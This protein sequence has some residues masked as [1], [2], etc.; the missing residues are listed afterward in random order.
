MDKYHWRVRL[1]YG[2]DN[3][4][5]KGL[6]AL[7]GLLGL[8]S[9][10]FIA[11]ISGIVAIFGLYPPD[12]P[13]GFFEVFWGSLLRTLDPGT[14]GQDDG[15]GFRAAML[16][17]TLSGVILVASLIGVIS[18]AFNARI[19]LLRKG[20]SR[21]LEKDHTLI[22]GWNSKVFS[23]IREISVANLSRTNPCIVILADRDK[24]EMEDEIH[25]KLKKISNSR[26][27][28]RSGDPM[29]LIDLEIANPNQARSIVILASDDDQDSDSV[30]I[31]ICMALVNSASR[32][33]SDYHIV[34]EIKEEENLEAA[35]LVGGHEAHWILGDD[36]IARL[37]VQTS[38]QSGLSAVF[39]ELLDFDG[40]ELYPTSQ[41]TLVGKTYGEAL[42]AF[43]RSCVLGLISGA[44]VEL[45]P[46]LGRKISATDQILVISEDDASIELGEPVAVDTSNFAQASRPPTLPE[47]TLILGINRKIVEILEEMSK[48]MANGSQ[49]VV[50][51]NQPP[52]PLKNIGSL[53]VEFLESDPTDRRVLESMDVKAFDHIVVLADLERFSVQRG[54]ARTLLTLL[55]LRDMAK[56]QGASL[57]IVSEMLDDRNRE[58]A[59]STDADDFIV[60]DKLVSLMMAQLE[61]NPGLAHVFKEFLTSDGSEIRLH[62]AEWYVQLNTE[63]DFNTVIAA[64][65]HQGESAVG[66]SI[67]ANRQTDQRLH[68]VT[69]NPSRLEKVRFVEGDRIVVLTDA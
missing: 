14:M 8:V 43:R 66:F 55:H 36:L 49:V 7:I 10:I 18:N 41:P 27:I 28:V 23:I 63:V 35:A 45:N 19:E 50:V 42:F 53:K 32:K 40:A 56:R 31:K 47:R 3:L 62:P 2:F 59:E 15:F 69:L 25:A 22:L 6:I 54:D 38:R 48:Y 65:S 34:G 11:L 44:S 61:E 46:E 68:G 29:S 4:M 13:L 33:Q 67:L 64:A 9:L 21:V 60:S 12:G 58:L 26:V 20:R 57:N 5:S 52:P 24:V 17:V 1:A 37:I 30:S 39:T 16:A 51:D